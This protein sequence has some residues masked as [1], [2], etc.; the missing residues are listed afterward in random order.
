M[1][2]SNSKMRLLTVHLLMSLFLFTAFQAVA[3]KTNVTGKVKDADGNELSGVTVQIKGTTQG[4][5]TSAT[6]DYSLPNINSTDTLQFS[7]I[8]MISEEVLVGNQSVINITLSWDLTALDEI[9]VVG[10]GTQEAKDVTGAVSTI[11]SGD[12]DLRP[13]T[14]VGSLIS[15][16]AAGVVINP[17]SGRPGAGISI[18]IRG[19]TSVAGSS[20][21]FV[22][23]GVP[24][25]TLRDINPADVESI[26]VLKDASSAAIYGAQGASGVVIIT[27]KTGKTEKPVFNFN[28]YAGF[29]ELRRKYDLLNADQ[30]QDLMTELGFNTNWARFTNDTN[31]QDEIFRTAGT[32][33]YQMSLAG[34]SNE[35]SYYI[36]GS[37]LQEDGILRSSG[38]ERANFKLNLDQNVNSWLKVGTRLG[39]S[40]YQDIPINDRDV[41]RRAFI[42]PPVIGVFNEDGM[43][44]TNPFQPLENPLAV[45]DG[46]ERTFEEQRFTGNAFV[47]VTFLENFTFKSNLGIEQASNVSTQFRDPFRTFDGVS[48]GGFANAS[49]SRFRYRIIDNLL[50]YEKTIGKHQVEA[51][52]GSIEQYW[53]FDNLSSSSRGFSSDQ[54]T[55]VGAGAEP[56]GIGSGDSERRNI[57]F[58]SRINYSYDDKYLLTLNARRDGSSRFGPQ[59]RWGNFAAGSVGW[60]I[61][62]ES[63]MQNVGFVSDLKLRVGWGINGNDPIPD[64][65]YR[66]LAV[67]GANFI[68]QEIDTLVIANGIRPGRIANESLKWEEVRQANIGIDFGLLEGRVSGSIDLYDKQTRDALLPNLPIPRTADRNAAGNAGSIQNRG[69]ELLLNTVNMDKAVKWETS[70]NLS[71]NRVKVL[72]MRGSIDFGGSVDDGTQNTAITREGDPFALFYG[73]QFVRVDPENGRAVYLDVNG[74]ETYTP[75]SDDRRVI[76]NPHPDFVYGVTNTLS[77]KGIGLSIF[78]QGTYGNDIVNANRFIT[79]K[80][81]ESDN[82]ST[83][84]IDRWREPGDITDIPGISSNVSVRTNNRLFSTRFIEDGSFLRVRALTL[85]YDLP[86]SFLSKFKI[87]NLKVYATGENLLTLTSYSGFDPEVNTFGGNVFT[88]GLDNTVYPQ[89]RKIIFGLNLTL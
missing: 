79:E 38:L 80:A 48:L 4:T 32:Q 7:F 31:W 64:F 83:A 65:A 35:T 14:Q 54:V 70:L 37:W 10:Y 24:V 81:S 41:I 23:D 76:G 12:L 52:V 28:S 45:T 30:Y 6:G 60:R 43:F 59:N 34:K 16:K 56:L 53:Q 13:N 50:S 46:L 85:S 74:E 67:S 36:S 26:S 51:L 88:R 2:N 63:F 11:G 27:T 18:N 33:N 78:L 5:I 8:G 69:V 84:V 20:P 22:V 49:Y 47:E 15:G 57:S 86:S 71:V 21:L 61:S 17:G 75:S 39:Y 44:A 9:I 3:Q 68:V 89:A 29:S 25:S 77:Y 72:D 42:A 1:R 87:K 62:E 40:N 66:D 19:I 73:Q 55:V 58:I 82:Q